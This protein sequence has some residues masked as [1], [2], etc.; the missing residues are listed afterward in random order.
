MPIDMVSTPLT[1][2]LPSTSSI[3]LASA[4]KELLPVTAEQKIAGAVHVQQRHPLEFPPDEWM[5]LFGAICLVLLAVT[6]FYSVRKYWLGRK[7]RVLANKITRW[8]ATARKK[9]S[10]A[11][12]HRR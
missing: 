7:R 11:K 1:D 8:E 5:V 6:I 2:T 10:K 9:K 3:R 4:Q 12:K